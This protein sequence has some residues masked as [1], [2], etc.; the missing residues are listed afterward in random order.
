MHQ[1]ETVSMY[2]RLLRLEFK[3]YETFLEEKILC[4]HRNG[5]GTLGCHTLDT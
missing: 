2:E 1:L 3:V 4:A 5:F